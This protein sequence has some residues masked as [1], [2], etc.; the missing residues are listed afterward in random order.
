ML[1]DYTKTRALFE[2]TEVD[3]RN[4][5][6]FVSAGVL[7]TF[8]DGHIAAVNAILASRV[9]D[10]YSAVSQDSVVIA[11]ILEVVGAGAES[12][13]HGRHEDS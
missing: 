1:L 6:V 5:I 2:R 10:G 11:P 9:S 12:T 13:H 4:V 3:L 7:N 8:G